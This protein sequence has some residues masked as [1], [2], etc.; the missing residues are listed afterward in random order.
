MDPKEIASIAIAVR[1]QLPYR[2]DPN[3]AAVRA[4]DVGN[5]ILVRDL[6]GEPTFWFVPFLTGNLACGFAHIDLSGGID[7]LGIYGATAIDHGSWIDASFFEGPPLA[8]VEEIKSRYPDATLSDPLFSYD[9]APTRLAWVVKIKHSDQ[10][11]TVV[12]ISGAGWYERPVGEER[13]DW[14]G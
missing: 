11:E 10:S 4:A 7:R 12:F 8:F 3:F 2:D 1:N 13:W 5:P 9:K 14:D 6:A